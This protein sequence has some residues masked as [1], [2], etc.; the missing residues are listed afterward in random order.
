MDKREL[1]LRRRLERLERLV[2]S[3]ELFTNKCDDETYEKCGKRR[4]PVKREAVF[5]L[6]NG[7]IANTVADVLSGWAD[8]SRTDPEEAIRE[9]RRMGVLK[10]ATNRWYPTEDDVADAVEFCWE[11]PINS[12]VA[13]L[14][15]SDFGDFTQMA[16]SLM[17]PVG[18]PSRSPDVTLKFT[19]DH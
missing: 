1:L 7:V 17:P 2:R 8:T 16:L 13:K 14:F 18:G 10:R 19:W 12:S 15:A 6:P 4:R 11:D 5:R 3:N 9:L